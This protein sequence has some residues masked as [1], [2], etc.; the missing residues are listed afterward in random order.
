M[1]PISKL[2]QSLEEKNAFHMCFGVPTLIHQNFCYVKMP[3]LTKISHLIEI[4]SKQN[5][6]DSTF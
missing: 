2:Y 4:F 3:F 6:Q 1:V 5:S